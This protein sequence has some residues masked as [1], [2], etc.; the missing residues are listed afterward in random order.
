MIK[1]KELVNKSNGI[2]K[3]YFLI[4]NVKENEEITCNYA[5]LNQVA[6]KM[7][8]YGKVG[9]SYNLAECFVGCKKNAD[10]IAEFVDR[11]G[12][13][14]DSFRFHHGIDE[15]SPNRTTKFDVLYVNVIKG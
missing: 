7:G 13:K 6:F 4:S 8:A 12:L 11:C 5:G 3:Y 1:A 14:I 10:T 9:N 2:D 15:L